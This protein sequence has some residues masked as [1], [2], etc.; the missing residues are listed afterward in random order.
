MGAGIN[1]LPK[2]P[3]EDALCQLTAIVM[4]KCGESGE[5]LH[6]PGGYLALQVWASQL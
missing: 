4:K 2:C 3:L 5:W 6:I 1:F